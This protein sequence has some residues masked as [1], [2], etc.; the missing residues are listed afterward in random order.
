[1]A[2]DSHPCPDDN[3]QTAVLLIAHGSRSPSANEEFA[4]LARQVQARIPFQRVEIAFLEVV[5][6]TVEEA[7]ERCVQAGATRV[8]LLPY[9]LFSGTHGLNDVERL[10]GELQRRHPNVAFSICR[11]LGVHP[12]LV[13]VVLDRVFEVVSKPKSPPNLPADSS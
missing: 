5:R 9:F 13:D 8:L 2:H 11:P 1:M 3:L 7:A 10:W 4:E 12:S 6:P